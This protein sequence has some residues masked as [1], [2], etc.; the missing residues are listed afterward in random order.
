MYIDLVK[1]FE[2]CVCIIQA[3]S[4]ACVCTVL[5]DA[6]DSWQWGTRQLKV[7]KNVLISMEFNHWSPSHW[8]AA[9]PWIN[10][11]EVCPKWL[12]EGRKANSIMP[13]LSSQRLNHYHTLWDHSVQEYIQYCQKTLL[14][15]KAWISKTLAVWT[16]PRR[17]PSGDEIYATQTDADPHTLTE[18]ESIISLKIVSYQLLTLASNS[19][20]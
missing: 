18:A 5:I 9:V 3:Y 2:W 11:F 13:S 1:L 16:K 10:D 14:H 6:G 4:C 15:R 17:T 20:L 12:Q 19:N 7:L 8:T